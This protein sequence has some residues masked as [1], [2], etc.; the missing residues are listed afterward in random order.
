MLI[1]SHKSKFN[2]TKRTKYLYT[3]DYVNFVNPIDLI[4][5]CVLIS[6]LIVFL[7]EIYYYRFTHQFCSS[8]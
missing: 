5:I 2:E 6:N 1:L 3:N 4:M 7:V 8:I